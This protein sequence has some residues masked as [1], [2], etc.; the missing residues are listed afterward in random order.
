MYVCLWYC[1]YKNILLI[2]PSLP[3]S[4]SLLIYVEIDH[5]V[6]T[7]RICTR[8]ERHD[9]RL[10]GAP[11]GRRSRW[12]TLAGN[13]CSPSA[14]M[15]E[16]GQLNYVDDAGRWPTECYREWPTV[17]RSLQFIETIVYMPYLYSRKPHCKNWTLLVFCTSAFSTFCCE[18]VYI[19]FPIMYIYLFPAETK[20]S[21]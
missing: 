15:T 1:I 2:P 12:G 20:I 9:E 14:Q 7:E 18:T 11:P 8:C 16:Q 3:F 13:V 17:R 10:L 19:F 5:T 6:C 4:Q 21:R